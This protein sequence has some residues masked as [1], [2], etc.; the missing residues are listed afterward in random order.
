MIRASL[1]SW[2]WAGFAALVLTAAC[3]TPPTPKCQASNCSGCCTDDNVCLGAS[4]Q[5][6]SQCG[7]GAAKCRSCLPGQVCSQLRCVA[8]E[9]GGSGSGGGEGAGG[10][11]GTGGGIGGSGG[12]SGVCGASG[13]ACCVGS[14][15]GCLLGL[16]CNGGVCGPTMGSGGGSGA[17][18]GGSGTGGGAGGTGGMGGGVSGTGGGVSG[19][20]GGGSVAVGAF[21]DPCVV[22]SNCS[23]NF[24]QAFGFQDGYC[25]KTC[26]TNGDCPAG[27]ACGR[28]PA[29]GGN[30]CLKSCSAAGQA[31]GT[32]R[33]GYVCEKFQS[34]TDGSPVCFPA[35]A[36]AN[37]C[38]GGP[39]TCDGR[40]FCC[41]SNGAACCNNATCA[42]GATCDAAAKY[43][44]ALPATNRPAG[45]S[46]T[47][48]GQCAGNICVPEL[49]SAPSCVQA[50]WAGG[51]CTQ[52]CTSTACPSGSSCSLYTFANNVKRC[53]ANC[54][55]DGGQGDC[56]DSY[57]C[58]RY[59]V[60]GSSQATCFKRCNVNSSCQP[61]T[62]C[63]PNGFCCGAVGFRCCAAATCPGGGTCNAL[64]YCQ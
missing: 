50:C 18:G 63:Q 23:T 38:V 1:K 40:G 41:G 31:P 22:N 54:Q 9:G 24:C 21:G 16:F 48:A 60:V 15:S 52:D 13:Q 62:T 43:C 58:D 17:T 19:T 35:C 29:G 53:V 44:K 49:V 20:G 64:D 45:E 12:G 11:M 2:V 32:C 36:S 47:T 39:V 3:G 26:T 5:A 51:Y 10:G 34:S 7:Q 27:G 14:G 55:W 28:N 61:G 37:S 42:G 33:A 57:I 6:Y 56:R 4:K 30:I 8:G 46:C 59:T 25:T